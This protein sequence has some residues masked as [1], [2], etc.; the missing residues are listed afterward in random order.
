MLKMVGYVWWQPKH[1]QLLATVLGGWN[2]L[3]D[4]SDWSQPKLKDLGC[5]PEL[6]PQVQEFLSGEGLPC[7]GDKDDSDWSLTPEPL[8]KESNKC[9]FWHTC[10][11]EMPAWWPELWRVPS[12]KDIPEF[13]RQVWASFQMPRVRCHT[14]KMEND[15]LALPTPHC[16]KRDVFLP[17]STV[18][19][20]GQDYHMKQPQK[21]W[22]MPRHYNFGWKS[23]N[24]PCPAS[25]ASWQSVCESWGSPWSCWQ[26]SQMKKSSATMCHHT[27]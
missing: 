9:I 22:H 12:Q 23:P 14:E 16:I 11:V 3:R 26:H 20:N 27:G 7:T 4:Q 8:F 6:D 2:G 21:W 25:H 19:S 18:K 24:C 17:F 15:Y 1:Q 13:A 10:Q 5:P